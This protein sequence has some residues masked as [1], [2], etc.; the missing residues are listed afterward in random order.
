MVKKEVV[1]GILFKKGRLQGLNRVVIPRELLDNLNINEGD[2]INL[3]LDVNNSRI[4]L[5]KGSLSK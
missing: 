5:K 1:D 4:I 3:Y 2:F